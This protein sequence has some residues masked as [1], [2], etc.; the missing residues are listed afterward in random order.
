MH[1]SGL[2][3]FAIPFIMRFFHPLHLAGFGRRTE[4]HHR[5]ITPNGN[6]NIRNPPSGRM[7]LAPNMEQSQGLFSTAHI[8]AAQMAAVSRRLMRDGAR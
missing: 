1:D 4:T 5:T 7:V 3:W 6:T 2:M 8:L